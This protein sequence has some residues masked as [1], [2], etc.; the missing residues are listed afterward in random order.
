MKIAF[1]G[2]G[3]LGFPCAVALAMKGH[4]VFCYDTSRELIEGY[5]RGQVTPF[6]PGLEEQYASCKHLMHYCAT[7]NDAVGQSDAIY[8][9][10][11]TP[12]AP[13]HDGSLPYDGVPRDFDNSIIESSL[14]EVGRAIKAHKSDGRY[15]TILV[16]STVTPGTM[17]KILGP[18]TERGAESKIGDGWT[19][20]YNPF[21]IGQS[22][23]VRDFLNP[24][25][26]LLGC[27]PPRKDMA[28]NATTPADGGKGESVARELYATLHNSPIRPMTWTEAECVKLCYN[29]YLGLKVLFANTVMEVCHRLPDADCDVVNATLKLAT[30]RLVSPKYMDGG[31]ADGGPC[32]G[33][34]QMA[35]S[36]TA[37]EVGLKFNIF[38]VI[39]HGRD[40]QTSWLADQVMERRAGRPVVLLGMAFKPNTNQTQGSPA[41]LLANILRQRGVFPVLH[42]PAIRPDAELPTEPALYFISTNW[43][44][45]KDF[46]FQPG[47]TVIDPWRM[48]NPRTVAEGVELISLGVGKRHAKKAGAETATQRKAG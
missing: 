23:V 47:D 22:T 31:M 7:V 13:S 4:E 41:I 39:N 15:R 18:A 25:F 5:K 45:Y 48:I 33:R 16:I 36:F 42:D 35:M 21:F 26:V 12:H 3:K 46:K 43:K 17:N 10:V 1:I 28:I 38:D 6:E 2:V 9:A 30:D 34:D 27:P 8:V 20:V 29:T 32:H 37:R 40:S 14:E 24:E 19:M 11:P 44:Q